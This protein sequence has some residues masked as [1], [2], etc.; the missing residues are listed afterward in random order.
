MRYQKADKNKNN[1]RAQEISVIGPM[2]EPMT[3]GDLPAPGT[4]R[5]VVR[6]KA[7]V[8]AGVRGGLISLK[9]ACTRY[10]LSEDEFETWLK[11][12]QIHGLPG[13]RATG[14]KKYRNHLPARD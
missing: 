11:Q 10:N 5:W 12:F 13:L 7:E 8:V 4:E 3:L 1:E 14:L 6:R 2:G 9:E